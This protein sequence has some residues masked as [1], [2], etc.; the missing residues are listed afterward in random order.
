MFRIILLPFFCILF[1]SL[2]VNAQ[3]EYQIF[4]NESI[5]HFQTFGK[6]FPVL[7]ING[8]PG[9]SSEGFIPLAQKLSSNNRTIIYDQRGTG[10]S[11]LNKVDSETVTLDLMVKDI[12]AIR[13]HLN[14][15]TWVVLGH[16]F[17]GIMASYYTSKHPDKVNGLILSSSGGL[18]ME[19]F[20]VI[21]IRSR[22][23]SVQQD[24]LSYWEN[25]IQRGDTSYTALLN[26][27][28]YLAPAY[29]N[30]KTFIPIIAERLTQ[31]NATI[32]SLVYQSMRRINYD[33]K[34]DLSDFKKPVLILQGAHD[35][36]PLSIFE[37]AHS[38]FQNS[39]FIIFPNSGHYGW[40]EDS[41][42]Y[43]ETIYNFLGL[44]SPS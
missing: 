28:K 43:F 12:E 4:E 5:I 10:K 40:L 29:L 8:G 38:I 18:D 23:T 24:S 37:K 26:R 1:T 11:T 20:D 16:S 2:F 25:R 36:I 35:I 13:K 33:T 15:D 7:I 3:T 27:G 14:I 19:L 30:D 32:N 17:G 21:N 44:V 39:E 34:T 31:G 9:M 22:L 6:G 41:E 42:L